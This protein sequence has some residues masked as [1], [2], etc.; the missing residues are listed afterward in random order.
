MGP[1]DIDPKKYEHIEINSDEVRSLILGYL[2]HHGFVDTAQAFVESCNMKEEWTRLGVGIKD[3]KGTANAPP[4]QSKQPFIC[5]KSFC[6]VGGGGNCRGCGAC[7]KRT[8]RGSNGS[9]WE[10]L[11]RVLWR[12]ARC[13]LQTAVPT[14]RGAHTP[15]Q[16]GRSA[17][18]RSEG[19]EPSCQRTSQVFRRVAGYLSRFSLSLSVVHHLFE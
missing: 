2:L 8:D 14:I 7:R 10:T 4:P 15:P 1:D 5:I 13:A 9:C 12:A 11:P 18:V 19:V 16:E 6:C 17:W 3:R